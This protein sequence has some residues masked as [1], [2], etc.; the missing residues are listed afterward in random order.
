MLNL[1]LYR[2]QKLLLSFEYGLTLSEV[3]RKRKIK[4]TPE[5]VERMEHIILEEFKKCTSERLAIDMT[6]N[7]LAAFETI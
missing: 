6:V 7:I 1:P 2:N 5:T 4:L 3:A